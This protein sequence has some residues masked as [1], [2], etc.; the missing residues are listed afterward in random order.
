VDPRLSD[1]NPTKDQVDDK[2]SDVSSDT[3]PEEEGMQRNRFMETS[4]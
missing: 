2:G 1:I 3:Q 4:E